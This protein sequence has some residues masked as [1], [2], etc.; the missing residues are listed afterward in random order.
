MLNWHVLESQ[1]KDII[2]IVLSFLTLCCK[3]FLEIFFFHNSMTEKLKIQLLNIF[4]IESII[5]IYKYRI[6][7]CEKVFTKRFLNFFVIAVFANSLRSGFIR[8]INW[9]ICIAFSSFVFVKHFE[10]HCQFCVINSWK[11]NFIFPL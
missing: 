9:F 10:M 6:S 2:L 7:I 4:F 11:W 8:T 1:N 5:N 3:M